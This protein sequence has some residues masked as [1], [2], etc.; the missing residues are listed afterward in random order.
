MAGPSVP[1]VRPGRPGRPGRRLVT[2][3]ASISHV[4]LQLFTRQGF[5][6]TSV[7]E[8]ADAAGISRR[9]LFR[10]YASKNDVPW[11]DFDAELLRMRAFL[12]GLPTDTPLADGLRLALLDFNTFPQEE[13]GF[14]RQR[15]TLLLRV[16]ALQAHSTLKYGGWRRVVA[17]HVADHLGQRPDDHHPRT[18]AWLLLG[19][20]LA[21]YEQ[22]LDD[23]DADLHAL[24]EAG[25][26][27]VL[28][29]RA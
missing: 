8:I 5:E 20:A 16:P 17:E 14:H 29:D 10:Y 23:A 21:A 2:T 12:D 27:L 3:R 15:M 11:G 28:V 9:T 19:V 7:D 4:G 26:E 24:L 1:S 6:Q 18:V 13:T 25:A 22:W